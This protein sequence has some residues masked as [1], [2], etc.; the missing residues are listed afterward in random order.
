MF[1]EVDYPKIQKFSF[2]DNIVEGSLASVTCLAI[3]KTKPI[4]F[5]W[6]KNG[7]KITGNEEN[8][9]INT[10]NEVTTIIIDP[11][12]SGDNGNFTCSASNVHGNDK[13]TALLQVKGI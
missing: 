1:A 8:V 10:A 2:Q 5:E 7:E 11:V 4:S 12:T 3:T 13:Y 9:R 6:L